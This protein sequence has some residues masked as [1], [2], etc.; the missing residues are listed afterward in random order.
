[1][2]RCLPSS[3]EVQRMDSK[4]RGFPMLVKEIRG[5]LALSQEDLARNLGVSYATVNRWENGLRQPSR[6]AKQQVIAFCQKM[7][8]QGKLVLSEGQ[9][10]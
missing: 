7:T 3:Q 8:K 1:M 9:R 4:V 5:Q 6:L 10:L 2:K